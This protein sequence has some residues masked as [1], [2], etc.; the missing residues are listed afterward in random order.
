MRCHR[1]SCIAARRCGAALIARC[2][3]ALLLPGS[4]QDGILENAADGDI[5]AVFGIGFPPFM[6]GPFRYLDRL[7]VQT[8]VDRMQRYADRVGPHFAPAPLLVD[9][10]KA[11]KTFHKQ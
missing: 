5:G 4:L 6:G 11:G 8:F 3:R 7:G 9:M 2:V 1:C 10:A